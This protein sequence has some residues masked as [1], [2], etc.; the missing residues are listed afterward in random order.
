MIYAENMSSSTQFELAEMFRKTSDE[1]RDYSQA[2]Q[3]F[4]HSAKQGYRKA[5]YKLGLMYARGF[6]VSRDYVKA[7][8]WLKI[9]AKQGSRKALLCLNKYSTK[10]PTSEIQAAHALSRQYYEKYV[11]PFSGQY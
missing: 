5:Q 8:A 2:A 1:C 3:W 11:I 10:I 7:Y 4:R 9:A 6:G